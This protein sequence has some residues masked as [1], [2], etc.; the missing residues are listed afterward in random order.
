MDNSKRDVFQGTFQEILNDI[1][2]IYHIDNFN[3][4]RYYSTETTHKYDYIC[5]IS[6]TLDGEHNIICYSDNSSDNYGDNNTKYEIF[7]KN[8]IYKIKIHYDSKEIIKII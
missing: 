4:F 1:K 5:T 3:S 7:N 6:K 2:K 8:Q